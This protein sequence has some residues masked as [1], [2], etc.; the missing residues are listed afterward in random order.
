M[1]HPR[2]EIQASLLAP[3]KP[4]AWLDAPTRFG[5]LSKFLRIERPSQLAFWILF[6]ATASLILFIRIYN[7][8]TYHPVFAAYG[9]V[10]GAL[11]IARYVFFALYNPP[12]L[13]P[14][15]YEPE[16]A[17]IIPAKNESM[18]I[19][20]TARSLAEQDY[21]NEKLTV[22]L[23][24]MEAPTTPATGWI[25]QPPTLASRSSI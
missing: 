11:I 13:P 12:L 23:I 21:P 22:V 19:Y 1:P 2:T 7:V 24:N 17:A 15:V 18:G 10:V 9:A 16:V 20:A 4:L 14:D 5:G 6:A 3:E 8:F 25:A